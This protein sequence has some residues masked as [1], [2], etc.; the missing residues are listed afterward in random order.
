L[1]LASSPCFFFPGERPSAAAVHTAVAVADYSPYQYL[2]N[3]QA[4]ADS[5]CRRRLW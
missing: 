3:A 1:N 2:I 4:F 5:S